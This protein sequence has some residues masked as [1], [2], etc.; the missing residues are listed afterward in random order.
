LWR[1]SPDH[2]AFGGDIEEVDMAGY[3]MKSLMAAA[4]FGSMA[5]ASFGSAQ[6]YESGLDACSKWTNE[7]AGEQ[8]K[9]FDCM[10][11]VGAGPHGI[12]PTLAR[13]ITA[14][15]RPADIERSPTAANGRAHKGI[16]GLQTVRRCFVIPC[17]GAQDASGPVKRAWLK[18]VVTAAVEDR[19]L[20]AF[21]ATC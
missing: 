1:K 19:G 7:E 8:Y 20:G 12:G 14:T 6:A 18:G 10:K 9:C 16:A 15:C 11:L 21:V 2:T 17:V 5:A 4:V 3:A 13:S